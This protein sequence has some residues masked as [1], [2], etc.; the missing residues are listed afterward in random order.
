MGHDWLFFQLKGQRIHQDAS[1][2]FCKRCGISSFGDKV[3][4]CPPWSSTT[5]GETKTNRKLEAGE[6][7]Q[8]EEVLGLIVDGL[9]HEGPHWGLLKLIQG[10]L[11]GLLIQKREGLNEELAAPPSMPKGSTESKIQQWSILCNK[12]RKVFHKRIDLRGGESFV[13]TCLHCNT[14]F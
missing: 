5:E 3:T 11:S 8:L 1:F 9:K 2:G 14:G 6:V 7:E 12:C 10:K 13:F 4:P